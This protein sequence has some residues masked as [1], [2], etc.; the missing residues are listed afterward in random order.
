MSIS[1]EELTNIH[2]VEAEKWQNGLI[3]RLDELKPAYFYRAEDLVALVDEDFDYET[4]A[5]VGNTAF[6][7]ASEE[8]SE[9][10]QKEIGEQLIR[11]HH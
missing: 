4:A 11:E 3:E 8:L 2:F 10:K 1:K 9:S 5:F 7:V 6:V